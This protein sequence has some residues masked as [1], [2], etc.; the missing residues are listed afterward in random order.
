M[1]FYFCV[2]WNLGEWP[3]T[4]SEGEKDQGNL[5]RTDVRRDENCV[6]SKHTYEA[7]YKIKVLKIDYDTWLC[8]LPQS[9]NT[10]FS[11]DKIQ[12]SIIA[13]YYN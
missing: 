5:S 10:T 4:T 2:I 6:Y 3:E 9:Q 8:F 12:M 7:S 13:I 1:D 11:A